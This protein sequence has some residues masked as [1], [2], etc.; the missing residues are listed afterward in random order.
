MDFSLAKAI[1]KIEEKLEKGGLPDCPDDDIIPNVGNEIGTG[2]FPPMVK[3]FCSYFLTVR[4]GFSWVRK[5]IVS[6]EITGQIL[7][8]LS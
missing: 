6:A 8:L 2:R 1:S 7:K 4:N 5:Q 3:Y